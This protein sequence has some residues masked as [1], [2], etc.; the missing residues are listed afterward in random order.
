ML[1][2]QEELDKFKDYVVQQS[3]SNLT[4]LKKNSSKNL[5]NSIKGEAKAMPNSFY[6]NFEM[7]PYGKFIDKGVNGKKT[8]YSTPYS[9][10]TKMPP[11][12]KLDKWIVRKG[13]A[14]RNKDGK[15]TGRTINSVGFKKSI[16]FLIA[17][18]IFM[19]GI[20]P[21]LFFTKPFQKYFE[22]L[23]QELIVKY[24]LDVEELFKHTIKQPK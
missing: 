17:R 24:G 14:P 21:S 20:K 6:L 10:K 4:R 15:F 2:V 23:P 18:K 9:Y 1:N 7:E 8:T 19:Y 5:Y 12:S 22:K 3:K 16:Q 13:L 11:P